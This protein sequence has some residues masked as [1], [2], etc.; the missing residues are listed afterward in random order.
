MR[1]LGW[2]AGARKLLGYSSEE[3]FGKKCGQIMQ[4]YLANGQQLCSAMCAG[5]SCMALGDKWSVDVCRIR[6]KNGEM[7][8]ASFSTMV[9]P[10][11]NRQDSRNEGI[12]VILIR[13]LEASETVKSGA[14]PLRIFTLGRFGLAVD[15]V[16]LDADHWRR[17]QAVTLLKILISHAGR[18]VHREKLME[19][20]WPDAE[21]GRGWERLKVMISFLR[22][23]LRQAGLEDEVIE[24]I[25]K[26]YLLRRESVVLDSHTFE[27]LVAN[28]WKHLED[29][30]VPQALELFEEARELCR[31]DHMEDEP[32]ADWCA[33]AR[34]CLREVQLK[35][36]AG[37]VDCYGQNHRHS[38]AAEVCRTALFRDPCRESFIRSLMENLAATGRADWA[39]AQ[40]RTWRLELD[41]QYGLE[42]TL[43]TLRLHQKIVGP[44]VQEQI[45][46][47]S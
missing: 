38:E 7:V 36:Y 39:D 46:L 47:T 11:E 12:A 24:T 34:E 13:S 17:K 42:P 1:I 18:P 9:L 6:H 20:L 44:R 29:K 43:E 23:K 8:P 30:Q 2:N 3:V 19:W 14:Q 10:K 40:F 31:G 21:P 28:G 33:E 45:N 25:G 27:T 37:L 5:K 15:G 41:Q 35:M 4:A 16:D 32:Y 22:G 26:S